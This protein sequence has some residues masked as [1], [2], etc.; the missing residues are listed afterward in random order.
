MRLSAMNELEQIKRQVERLAVLIGARGDQLP[1]YGHSEQTGR[2]HIEVNVRGY[3]YVTAERGRESGRWTTSDLDELLYEVFRSVT[4]RMA[5]EYELQHRFA[6]QDCRRLIFEKQIELI[7]ALSLVW[8]GR[9]SN[10]KEKILELYPFDD[11]GQLRATL[12]KEL[13]DRG[14][15]AEDSWWTACK[16]YPLPS[17]GSIEDGRK[18]ML[19]LR[20]LN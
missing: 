14:Q 7:S 13:R 16:K 17:R 4:F 1:T 12:T 9:L 2:P 5:S 20:K 19:E 11:A 6:E 8:A 10:E 18:L 15:S 3:H